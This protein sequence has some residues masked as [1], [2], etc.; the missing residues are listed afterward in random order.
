MGMQT[1]E[2]NCSETV[3]EALAAAFVEQ[4]ASGKVT[5]GTKGFCLHLSFVFFDVVGAQR[6]RTKRQPLRSL[7]VMRKAGTVL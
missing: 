5:Y 3:S 7:A 1:V 6:V 4:A 2:S